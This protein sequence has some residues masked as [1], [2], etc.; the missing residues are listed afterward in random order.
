ME[1]PCSFVDLK[2]NDKATAIACD[3]IADNREGIGWLKSSSSFLWNIGRW[4]G[5]T[6]HRA[7]VGMENGIKKERDATPQ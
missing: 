3:L 5:M 4:N 2:G 7:P 6:H 1:L